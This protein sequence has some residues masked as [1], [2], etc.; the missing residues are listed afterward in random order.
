MVWIKPKGHGKS[1]VDWAGDILIDNKSSKEDIN[2]SLEILDNWRAIHRYPMHIFKRRLK[3]ISEK[4]S[5]DALAVQRLK[6][7]PSVLKK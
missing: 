6:R 4:M 5:S 3:G 2:K 7:L 1:K